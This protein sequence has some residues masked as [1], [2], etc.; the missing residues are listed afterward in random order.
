VAKICGG[1][2]LHFQ[3]DRSKGRSGGRRLSKSQGGMHTNVKQKKQFKNDEVCV[4]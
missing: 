3:N 1:W 2:E 4:F